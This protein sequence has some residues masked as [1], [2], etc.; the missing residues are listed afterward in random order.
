MKMSLNT[1][2]KETSLTPC[3]RITLWP[4]MYLE[5]NLISRIPD[6]FIPKSQTVAH[7][8]ESD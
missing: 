7:S 8:K 4:C 2:E 1:K 3:L 6:H 5:I